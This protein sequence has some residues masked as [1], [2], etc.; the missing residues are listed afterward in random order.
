MRNQPTKRDKERL[1]KKL[2]KIANRCKKDNDSPILA[3]TILMAVGEGT[4]FGEHLASGIVD[5]Y[6]WSK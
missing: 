6:G 3:R 2:L 4:V 1:T 5:M